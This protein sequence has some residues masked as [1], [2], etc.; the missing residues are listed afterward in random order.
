MSNLKDNTEKLSKIYTLESILQSRSNLADKLGLSYGGDRDLYKALGYTKTPDFDDFFAFY[1]RNGIAKR[2][3]NAPVEASWRLK[4]TI[5]ESTNKQ[6]KF[7]K[8]WENLVKKYKVWHYLARADRLSGIGNYG[9]LV[10]GFGDESTKPIS[11]NVDLLYMRPYSED[12]AQISKFVS[13][14][15][16]FR[17]GLPE[18]YSLQVKQD[19]RQTS[20]DN[21]YK[22][23]YSRCIHIAENVDSDDVYGMPR[24]L[25]ILNDLMN[26][27]KV[28]GGSAE[29][30]WR[31]A[32]PG[33]ALS[34]AADANMQ[35]MDMDELEDELQAYIHKLQRYIR[36]QG[37][38]I[39]ELKP[40]VSDPSNHFNIIIQ[41]ISAATNI[42]KRILIGSERGELA[43]SQDEINWG[44]YISYRRTDFVEPII[45][46]PFIQKMID[47]GM[48]P[49]PSND[50]TIVWPDVTVP[51]EKD[52]AEVDRIRVDT[53]NKYA[54]GLGA[55][56]IVPK[57]IFL[58]KF[59]DF[60]EEEIQQAE[61]TV[62]KTDTEMM[63]KEISETDDTEEEDVKI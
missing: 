58:K 52:Q 36:L 57:N 12:N 37:I 6:T 2:V 21:I 45:L 54:T 40:Q 25:P 9:V 34:A 61:K 46:R 39:Q 14:N 35:S 47:V 56:N 7:E 49:E 24:L 10:L 18:E 11:K 13:D 60:T 63:V 29:M 27:E 31:G 30:F 55:E 16:D 8:E 62:S 41:S 38:D 1:S 26:L 15:K 20:I 43:S 59:L 33:L 17:Y 23:H 3:V 19:I 5:S 28:V 22:V 50:Y 42:P 53:L 51:T 32:F 44:K 48:L 4:P